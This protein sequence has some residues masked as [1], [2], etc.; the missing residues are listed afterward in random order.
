MQTNPGN[1]EVVIFWL[2]FGLLFIGF[3]LFIPDRGHGGDLGHWE[4][5]TGF[6]VMEGLP[7]VYDYGIVYPTTFPCN[8]PPIILYFFNIFGMVAPDMDFI[9]KESKYFKVIPLIFDFIS[10]GAIFLLIKRAAKNSFLPLLLLLSPAFMYNSYLWGQ[11]DSILTAFIALSLIFALRKNWVLS[12]IFYIVALNTK[13]QAVV[14]L[15]IVLLAILPLVN[16]WKKLGRS[17]LIIVLIQTLIVLPFLLHGTIGS[18][19][20]VMTSLVD[21]YT[22]VSLNAFNIWHLFLDGET[23]LYTKDYKPFWFGMTYKNW[24]LL[25]F[26]VFSFFALLP[27]FL[28][29]LRHFIQ[30]TATDHHFKSLIFLT[31]FLCTLGFF[32]FN[33]QMHER[34]SHPAMLMA[35]LYGILRKNYWL[36]GI[37]SIAYF[38]NMER[39]LR[40]FDMYYNTFIFVKPFIASIFL[41]ALLIGIWQLY[42]KYPLSKD[43]NFLY[44]ALFRK[45]N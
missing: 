5:W 36:Y 24:G 8:Y 41:L 35:F 31:A 18:W 42:K 33:T 22:N 17:V 13:M 6:M 26:M 29:S 9:S 40:F 28:K 12:L 16:S 39:T 27:V 37:T 23:A 1:R 34:Y 3:L 25:F 45:N 4:R 7:H 19:Y 10:A 14:F 2:L 15:P 30:R 32:F 43:W 38:L 20:Q 11:M 21:Q 44:S